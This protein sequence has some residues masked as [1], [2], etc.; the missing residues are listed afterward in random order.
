MPKYVAFSLA[1]IVIA[2]GCDTKPKAN[3]E[4]LQL[5]NAGGR[6]TLDG[7][8]LAGAVVSF[9][10]T[11]DDTFSY[12]LTN[13]SGDYTLQ[14]DSVMKGVKPG[15]KIVRVSTSRKILGLNIKADGSGNTATES[16]LV[17]TKYNKKSELSVD[18][19]P[20]KTTYN[21]DLR[22]S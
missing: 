16:E 11:A 8:P 2:A 14:L 13:S 17:P 5:L 9:D 1:L 3:Y 12:G 18:V 6:I 21:F 22:T 4:K 19:T 20:D 7:Q 10:D 15:N